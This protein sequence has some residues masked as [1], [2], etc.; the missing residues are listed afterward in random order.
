MKSAKKAAD[1]SDT[2]KPDS[3]SKPPV[4]KEPEPKAEIVPVDTVPK[5][6]V[7]RRLDV[8]EGK[9][10]AISQGLEN[11]GAEIFGDGEET[12]PVQAPEADAGTGEEDGPA[13]SDKGKGS[14]RY[15]RLD[16]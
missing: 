2:G 12:R 15:P 5:G 4:K 3:T 9:L 14:G 8:L 1:V 7:E 11:F 16:F 13:E 10:D 6:R